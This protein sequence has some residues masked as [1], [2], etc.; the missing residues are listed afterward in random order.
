MRAKF[1]DL[2]DGSCYLQRGRMR[3]KV[4]GSTSATVGRDGRVRRRRVS[5]NPTVESVPCDVRHLGVGLR[6]IPDTVMEMGRRR[7]CP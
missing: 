1:Q 5:G 7:R 4:S 6:R 3:K 2:T